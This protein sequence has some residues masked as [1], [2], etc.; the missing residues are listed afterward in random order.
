RVNVEMQQQL[1]LLTV[2]GN[3]PSNDACTVGGY[4]WLY[5]FD[6]QTGS[7]AKGATSNA[8]AVRLGSNAL[9][10]GVRL[11]R[12]T[13]GKVVSIVTDTGGGVTTATNPSSTIGGGIAKRVSW[14]E[15]VN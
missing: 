6:Y 14:R 11:T 9:V 4:A 7:F 12:L 3:V 15:L 8:V 5:N 1:G 13:T 2:A 10:A